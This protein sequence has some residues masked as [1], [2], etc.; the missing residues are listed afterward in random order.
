MKLLKTTKLNIKICYNNLKNIPPKEYSSI[1]EMEESQNILELL[2]EKMQ[3][4]IVFQKKVDALVLRIERGEK[5]DKEI[6]DM[7]DLIRISDEKDMKTNVSIEFEDAQFSAFFQ[8]FEKWG[9]SWFN[10]VDQF[11]SF[12][13]DMND[14][15]KQSNERKK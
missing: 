11:L 10:K 2:K 9:K 12:R 5:L 8:Q 7:N 3:D 15:N 1:E 13:K 14:T 4:A 6:H